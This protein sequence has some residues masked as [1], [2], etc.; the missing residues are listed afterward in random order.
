MA[1]RVPHTPK[2]QHPQYFRDPATDKLLSMV[3]S[4][5]GE[6]AVTRDRVDTLERLLE[7]HG[8]FPQSEVQG[9]RAEGQVKEERDARRSEYLDRVMRTLQNDVD[10]MRLRE[11][12]ASPEETFKIVRDC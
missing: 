1:G 9:Y 12:P 4:L 6:L 10:E 8:V 2:G 3:L 5:T 11:N 7:K